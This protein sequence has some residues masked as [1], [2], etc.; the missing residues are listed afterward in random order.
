MRERDVESRPRSRRVFDE[1]RRVPEG[2]YQRRSIKVS[3]LPS[4]VRTS[5][6]HPPPPPPPRR[7][8]SRPRLSA[9]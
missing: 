9:V 4:L 8:R 5:L 2:F 1:G 3:Y 6:D 7:N